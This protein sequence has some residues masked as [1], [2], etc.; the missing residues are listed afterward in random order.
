MVVA[1]YNVFFF[2]MPKIPQALTKKGKGYWCCMA[3]V[4]VVVWRHWG[5]T[6]SRSVISALC[7]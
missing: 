6:R 4:L 3:V 7:L 5:R 1:L 2:Q